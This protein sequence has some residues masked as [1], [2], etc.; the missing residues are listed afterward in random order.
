M[1]TTEPTGMSLFW[2]LLITFCFLVF[3]AWMAYEIFTAP[4]IEFDEGESINELNCK[5]NE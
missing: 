2:F 1:E 5:D 3:V 4:T